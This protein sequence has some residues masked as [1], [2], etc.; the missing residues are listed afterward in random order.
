V[1]HPQS[2]YY[3]EE[4]AQRSEPTRQIGRFFRRARLRRSIPVFP[5]TCWG[6]LPMASASVQADTSIMIDQ[7]ERPADNVV[8]HAQRGTGAPIFRTPAL[9]VATLVSTAASYIIYTVIAILAGITSLM[10][11]FVSTMAGSAQAPEPKPP[12]GPLGLTL[13]LS[14]WLVF[15]SVMALRLIWCARQA[16]RNSSSPM[17]SDQA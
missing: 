10:R 4:A 3:S 9:I 5:K 13:I 7:S 11:S 6:K 17:L 8:S 16:S 15:A 2:V 14:P 12:Y 1:I